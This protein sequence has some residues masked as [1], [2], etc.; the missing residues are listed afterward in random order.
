MKVTIADP[1]PRV[2]LVR[3]LQKIFDR[4]AEMALGVG[5]SHVS[6]LVFKLLKMPP[7]RCVDDDGLIAS[8]ALHL[9]HA[10]TESL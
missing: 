1:A 10:M 3:R 7:G 2:L 6:E 9:S 4:F 8:R 5:K